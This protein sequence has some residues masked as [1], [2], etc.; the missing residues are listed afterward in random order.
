MDKKPIKALFGLVVEVKLHCLAVKCTNNIQ[1]VC[2]LKGVA[3]DENG[4]CMGMV[5]F[6]PKEKKGDDDN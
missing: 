2:N 4:M 5:K 3:N 6:K 1:Y